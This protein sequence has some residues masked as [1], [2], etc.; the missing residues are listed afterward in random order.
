MGALG[1][2]PS[3]FWAATLSECFAAIEGLAEFHGGKPQPAAPTKAQ[4]DD[5]L[6]KLPDA[7]KGRRL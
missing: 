3:E 4:V 1:W 6:L 2:P 7:P 5:L